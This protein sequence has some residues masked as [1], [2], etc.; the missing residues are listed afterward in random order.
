MLAPLLVIVVPPTVTLFFLPSSAVRVPVTVVVSLSLVVVLSEVDCER[1]VTFWLIVA[2]FSRLRLS[3]D[4]SRVCF[5]WFVSVFWKKFS[6]TQSFFATR[7][8]CEK[9][10]KRNRLNSIVFFIMCVIRFHIC[11]GLEI[12]F[13]NSLSRRTKTRGRYN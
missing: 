4:C 9:R 7:H 1:E 3:S 13:L 2:D 12:P 6:F 10:A 5:V 8:P 11:L